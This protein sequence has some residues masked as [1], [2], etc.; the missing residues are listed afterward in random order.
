MSEKPSF[1]RE[2]RD[3]VVKSGLTGVAATVL[4]VTVFSPAGLGGIVG[5]SMASGFGADAS[6]AS[7]DNPYA[8]LPA[9]RQPF[10]PQEISEVRGVL[11]S[12][13]AQMEFTRAATEARIEH[14]RTIASADSVAAPAP[15]P[16][17]TMPQYAQAAPAAAPNL[18][19]TLSEP[20]PTPVVE[21]VR[22]DERPVRVSY[23]GYADHGALHRDPHLELAELFLAHSEF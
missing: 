3:T 16:A 11:A 18:R 20:A 1:E 19:L 8:N 2:V 21:A 15:M 9:F 10:S 14:I 22:A 12:T 5:T 6:A 4:A 13:T 7:T 23:S 17:V